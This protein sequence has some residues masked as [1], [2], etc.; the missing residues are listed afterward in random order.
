MKQGQTLG[1]LLG[2]IQYGIL[3]VTENQDVLMKQQEI[4]GKKVKKIDPLAEKAMVKAYWKLDGY[5]FGDLS[6]PMFMKWDTLILG[7]CPVLMLLPKS[8]VEVMLVTALDAQDLQYIPIGMLD[9][10]KICDGRFVASGLGIVKE[11]QGKGLAKHLI[12]AGV[13]IAGIK[14]LMIP[15]QLSNAAAH[16]AWMHLSPLEIMSADVFH[17][18]ED[19]IIYRSFIENP[20]SILMKSVSCADKA[21]Y[22]T[23]PF[24]ELKKFSAGKKVHAVAYT[25]E[26]LV[27]RHG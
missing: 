17:E 20:E 3:A 16:Y 7:G 27:I 26:G 22:L 15:T 23:V 25:S 21:E 6:A 14:D 10:H 8:E 5:V 12:Y 24:K 2:H 11:Y 19:E 4:L 18:K 13:Q 1:D 9:L